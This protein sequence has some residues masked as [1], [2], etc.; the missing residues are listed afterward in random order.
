[1]TEMRDGLADVA[2]A[3]SDLATEATYVVIG[4]GVL[5]LRKAQVRRR[6][7]ACARKGLLGRQEDLD[8]TMAQLFK[9]VDSTVDPLLD[10]LPE[11]A[12]ALVRQTRDQLRARLTANA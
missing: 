3:L 8:E 4:F 12:Q 6:Q 10:L 9:T 2:R 7:L 5:G 11:Q 1:M